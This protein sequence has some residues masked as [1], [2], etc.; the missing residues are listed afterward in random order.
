VLG[1]GRTLAGENIWITLSHSFLVE[2]KEVNPSAANVESADLG[3]G[4][5][6]PVP[7]IPSVSGWCGS[8]LLL[9]KA[10]VL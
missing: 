2:R 4:T 5:S 3:P 10:I 6:W 9:Q 1:A 7:G 8:A